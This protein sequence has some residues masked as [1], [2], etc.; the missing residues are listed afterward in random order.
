M[1]QEEIIS[2]LRRYKGSWFNSAQLAFALNI[3]KVNINA[4]IKRMR[5]YD[6]LNEKMVR[7]QFKTHSKDVLHYSFKN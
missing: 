3:P 2:F 5:K 6:E 7:L 1:G 4:S